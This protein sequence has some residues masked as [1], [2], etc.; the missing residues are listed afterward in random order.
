MMDYY[1]IIE[2]LNGVVKMVRDNPKKSFPLWVF[3]LDSCSRELASIYKSRSIG[4]G[5][6]GKLNKDIAPLG[7]L[8]MAIVR[9]SRLCA[10]GGLSFS[11]D[12]VFQTIDDA[13]NDL[14]IQA[15]LDG[16]E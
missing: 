10:V 5:H 8:K 7:H 15:K 6:F 14:K 1:M 2:K 16:E 11:I 13:V 3:E 4:M 12:V 9:L